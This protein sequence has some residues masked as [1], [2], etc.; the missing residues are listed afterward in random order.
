MAAT[1]RTSGRMARLA[2]PWYGKPCTA[3][4][5]VLR[6]RMH[7]PSWSCWSK[8]LIK[9]QAGSSCRQSKAEP[10]V[11]Y[12]FVTA[13]AFHINVVSASVE[14]PRPRILPSY[15]VWEVLV[16]TWLYHASAGQVPDKN[17]YRY[18]WSAAEL[19]T[20][21]EEW[22]FGLRQ[23][24]RPLVESATPGHD[25]FRP[26]SSL[27]ASRPGRP[28]PISGLESAGS[29]VVPSQYPPAD[30]GRKSSIP[31]WAQGA[32]ANAGIRYV[33]FLHNTA[34]AMRSSLFASATTATFW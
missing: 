33:S 11:G 5:T 29:T 19:Q 24:I 13:F 20:K 25:G 31:F 7:A 30:L 17:Y 26:L 9:A 1:R 16:S 2:V 18:V 15:C 32:V 6:R 22:W 14:A 21:T 27:L 28:L 4:R 3:L 34:Q 8:F 23:C 12:H 10:S